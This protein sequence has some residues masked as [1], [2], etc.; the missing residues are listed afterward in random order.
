MF[1]KASRLHLRFDTPVGDLTV[2]D[3]WQLPL[4]SVRGRTDLDGVARGLDELVKSSAVSFVTDT[5]EPDEKLQLKFDIVKHIIKVKR[6]ERDTATKRA[7]NT[8][9][10]Q[11]LQSI[12]ASRADTALEGKSDEELK[13]LIDQL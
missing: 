6:E 7:A 13:A 5:S 11:R 2:E 8:A 12:L 4:T 10:K 3:L 9:L 1:E